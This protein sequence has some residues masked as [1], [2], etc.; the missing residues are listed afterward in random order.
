MT[1]YMIRCGE[2]HGIERWVLEGKWRADTEGLNSTSESSKTQDESPKTKRRRKTKHSSEYLS[3][4]F[5]SVR[6]EDNHLPVCV[7]GLEVLANKGLKLCKLCRHLETV[8]I[9][10]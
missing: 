7:L 1:D 10:V 8:L 2:R 9:K 4:G 3:L 5:T 6:P